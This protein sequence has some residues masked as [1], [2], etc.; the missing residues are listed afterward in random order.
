M[1]DKE[2]EASYKLL[3][4][5]MNMK[6]LSYEVVAKDWENNSKEW[7]HALVAIEDLPIVLVIPN[8]QIYAWCRCKL[9]AD[10]GSEAHFFIGMVL[11]ISRSKSYR[12]GN[13]SLNE[14]ELSSHLQ[15]ILSKR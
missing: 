7:Y 5:T 15:K 4:K 2:E 12:V 14:L 13:V 11:F 9:V 8:L 3:L 1:G 10:D 6:L